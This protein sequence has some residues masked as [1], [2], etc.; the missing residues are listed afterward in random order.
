[1]FLKERMVDQFLDISPVIR[2]LLQ[3][4]IQKVPDLRTDKQ[5]SRYLDLIL[6]NLDQFLLPRN[7]ERI[8]SNHHLI[9]HNT[10]RPYIYLLIIL[11]SLQYLRAD[12]ERSTAEGS[13]EFVILMNRPSK[14][15]EFYYVLY[16]VECTS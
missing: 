16:E 15:T 10:D 4:S 11:L 3:T 2:I 9:H 7:F 5:I 14:V 13:S 12:V 6:N 1:M 8:L